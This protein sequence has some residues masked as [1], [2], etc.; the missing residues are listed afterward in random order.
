MVFLD[1][2]YLAKVI[3]AASNLVG[4]AVADLVAE[5]G[6]SDCCKFVA[7]VQLEL[8]GQDGEKVPFWVSLSPRHCMEAVDM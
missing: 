7:T 6:S 8:W 4:Y 2:K 3:R 5:L 1:E